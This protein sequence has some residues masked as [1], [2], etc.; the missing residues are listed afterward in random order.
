VAVLKADPPLWR[1]HHGDPLPPRAADP[2]SRFFCCHPCWSAA[3]GVQVPV[4][5]LL[6]GQLRIVTS[7]QMFSIWRWVVVGSTVAAAVLTPSTDPF[8]QALL[9]IP[10]CALYMGGAAA[11]GVIERSR[12]ASTTEL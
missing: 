10:L 12:I 6:L 3:C 9:A 7:Q 2:C 5:Q 8:T 4:V 11:V 1:W